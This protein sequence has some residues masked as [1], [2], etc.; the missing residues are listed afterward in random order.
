MFQ[1]IETF[2]LSPHE[3]TLTFTLINIQHL[4]NGSP[5][6]LDLYP[7]QVNIR[8]KFIS[9]VD[10]NQFIV[11]TS[12]TAA[13]KPPA[14]AASTQPLATDLAPPAEQSMEF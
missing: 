11:S 2:H 13:N 8:T 1:L 12:E 4:Y 9:N 6:I 3:N 14:E 7:Q 5:V 10:V